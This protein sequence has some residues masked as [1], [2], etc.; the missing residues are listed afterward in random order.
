LINIDGAGLE[1]LTI[2]NKAGA[3]TNQF[4]MAGVTSTTGS[5]TK[6]I[7][8]GN[9][10]TLVSLSDSFDTIDASS[11]TGGLIVTAANRPSTAMTITGSTGNDTISME[12]KADVLSAGAGTGDTLNI[13]ANAVLGGFAIDLTSATDQV[14][15]YGGVANAAL[16][17]GF[18]HVDFSAVTGDF[19]GD[20][21]GTDLANTITTNGKNSNVDGG[22]GNDI[23]TGGAGADTLTGGA[24]NDTID[25]GTG[26]DTIS[27]GAGTDTIDGGGGADAMAAG[28]GVDHFNMAEADGVAATATTVADIAA[29][30]TKTVT[31][32]NGVD[33][34]TG[35]TGGSGGDQ[36]DGLNGSLLPTAVGGL[37]NGG[38][39]TDNHS[40]YS[41]GAW[42]STT[43]VFTF[44]TDAFNATTNNDAWV[45]YT[46]EDDLGGV[47]N[48]THVIILQDLTI[49]LAAANFV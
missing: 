3:S 31:Y 9:G 35:F 14:T 43:N 41:Y 48:S 1:T 37:A 42:N 11:S 36:I 10:G 30:D 38:S 27:A 8:T 4:E 18:E 25:G 47:K 24:G 39:I 16:Q 7:L 6:L 46:S 13:N 21:T 17:T 12:N 5:T 40:L 26:A 49:A 19:G 23:I 22:K 32:G 44:E 34:I 15:S 33:V 28:T 29:T 2:D 45:A 20:V